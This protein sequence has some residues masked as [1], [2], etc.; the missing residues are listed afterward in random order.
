MIGVIWTLLLKE[1]PDIAPIFNLLSSTILEY[2]TG[3]SPICCS[4]FEE[5]RASSAKIWGDYRATRRDLKETPTWQSRKKNL[6][7]IIA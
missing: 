4:I 2:Q 5:N 3:V 1:L 6:N 7:A